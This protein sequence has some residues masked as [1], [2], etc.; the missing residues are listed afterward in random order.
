[1]SLVPTSLL[2]YS[3]SSS[4]EKVFFVI[5]RSTCSKHLFNCMFTSWIREHGCTIIA[6]MHVGAY[7]MRSPVCR[8][9]PFRGAM[10]YSRCQQQPCETTTVTIHV[11]EL[12]SH[13]TINWHCYACIFKRSDWFK[14]VPAQVT[15]PLACRAY[16]CTNI[17]IALFT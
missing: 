5:M 2:L 14:F 12:L 15:V 7:N 10:Q 11:A 8:C 3:L 13:T 4:F 1:M 16:S 6:P 9:W 17:H